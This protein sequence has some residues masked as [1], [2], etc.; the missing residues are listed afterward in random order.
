MLSHTI[1][2][3]NGNI[4]YIVKA[5]YR[6]SYKEV[7]ETII[8]DLEENGQPEENSICEIE[9]SSLSKP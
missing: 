6:L 3:S 2:V 9:H 1:K 7:F 8:K 5:S 4:T